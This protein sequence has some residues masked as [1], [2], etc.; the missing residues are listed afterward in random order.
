MIPPTPERLKRSNVR[1]VEVMAE[2][3]D[4]HLRTKS[5]VFRVR[6]QTWLDEYYR[7]GEVVYDNLVSGQKLS[8][9]YN[10]AGLVAKP[11][12]IN[13]LSSGGGRELSYGMAISEQQAA[14]RLSYMKALALLGDSRDMIVRVVCEDRPVI[15]IPLQ[16]GRS[17]QEQRKTAIKQL[18]FGLDKLTEYFF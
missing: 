5:V 14:A 2:D 13:L 3:D 15:P 17:Y 18:C 6:N 8:A 10:R 7:A 12:S 1:L 9:L 16:R 4:G 11:A